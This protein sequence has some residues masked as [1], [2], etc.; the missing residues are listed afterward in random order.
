MSKEKSGTISDVNASVEILQNVYT[1]SFRMLI[2][3]A[4]ALTQRFLAKRLL[5]ND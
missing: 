5:Q 2:V 3:D 4:A 1:R